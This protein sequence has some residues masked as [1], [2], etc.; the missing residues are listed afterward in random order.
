MDSPVHTAPKAS[1][2]VKFI[3]C[4]TAVGLVYTAYLLSLIIP[5][6]LRIGPAALSIAFFG[7]LLFALFYSVNWQNK[8]SKGQ[9][10]SS[11][12]HSYLRG[13][14]RYW[15]AFHISFYGYAKLMG[16]QLYQDILWNNTPIGKLSG[17][18][19]TWSYFGFSHG[20]S[21]IIAFVQIGGSVLLLF[22]KTTLLGVCIL[23]PVLLNIVLIDAF[24]GIFQPIVLAI[25]FTLQLLF[26]FL[27][28][29]RD[30]VEIFFRVPAGGPEI[31]RSS[32]RWVI[33]C[34]V[35]AIPFACIY[36]LNKR[37]PHPVIAGKWD[38]DRMIRNG[39]T[40]QGDAWLTD[41]SAWKS[42]YIDQFC[43]VRICSNPYIYI[44]DR[45]IGGWGALNDS[46]WRLAFKKDD[47]KAEADSVVV[48]ISHYDGKHML[49]NTFIGR[50][51]LSLWLSRAK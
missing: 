11:K 19:L 8:E 35:I 25:V 36:S 15:L 44:K 23:L 28:R 31:F 37:I 1:W 34:L 48:S 9:L 45:S 4:F 49:W 21:A 12:R 42:I 47:K 20:L 41:P 24:Y 17:F 26:L 50:D 30:F 29:W 16:S 38:V 3:E 27:L 2:L 18:E 7:A 32:F 51:S 39:D 22:R 6:G 43:Q 40:V 14:M 5:K 13:L 33:R 46:R 10:D